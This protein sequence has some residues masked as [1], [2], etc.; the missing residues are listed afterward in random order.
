MQETQTR[1]RSFHNT[2]KDTKRNQTDFF[3]G[4]HSPAFGKGIYSYGEVDLIVSLL[5]KDNYIR[6]TA[7][8]TP[9]DA[10][11]NEKSATRILNGR[12]AS[13]EK[14]DLQ[15]WKDTNELISK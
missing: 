9:F 11:N 4:H 12:Q 5:S 3:G 7:A 10:A 13:I 8:P 14:C 1:D 15:Q 6:M 2:K